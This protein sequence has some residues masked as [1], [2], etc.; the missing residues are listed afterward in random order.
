MSC[1]TRLARA[2]NGLRRGAM[3]GEPSDDTSDV[4]VLMGVAGILTLCLANVRILT[5]S[6]LV[7]QLTRNAGVAKATFKQ[8][9]CNLGP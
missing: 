5:T 2:R 9:C 1:T 7:F 3:K 6:I 8:V 4:D